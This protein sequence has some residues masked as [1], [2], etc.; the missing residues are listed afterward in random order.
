MNIVHGQL[1]AKKMEAALAKARAQFSITP[2]LGIVLIEGDAPSSAY[3]KRKVDKA[4]ELNIETTVIRLPH[5]STTDAVIDAIVTLGGDDGIDGIMVQLPL[6]AHIDRSRVLSAIPLAKD[7]DVLSPDARARF[8]HEEFPILPPVVAAVQY[9]FEAYSVHTL[10]R[11]VLVLGHG[12]L[13]GAPLAQFM[14]QCGARVTVVDQPVRDLKEF[15]KDAQVIICGAGVPHLLKPEHV[16]EGVVVI[17][18]GMQRVEGKLVGDAHPDVALHASLFT[19]TPGGVG[20]LV[21]VA[22]MKNLLILARG[23]ANA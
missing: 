11:E 20:P 9:I 3:V 23:R 17:D 6:P 8:A 4:R 19:P 13:V 18:A 15:T 16:S 5:E 10:G 21:V 2:G 1:L 14:R 7:V 22:L 12:I